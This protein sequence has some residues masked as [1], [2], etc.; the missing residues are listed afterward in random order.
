MHRLTVNE[1]Y[2][3]DIVKKNNELLINGTSANMDIKK[4]HGNAWHAINNLQSYNIEV[5]SFNKA[6]KAARIKVNNNIYIVS[7][8]DEFDILLDGLGLNDLTMKKGGDVKAPM[9]GMV[10]K[11]FIA[12]GMEVKKD[13]NLFI[14]EAMKME[15]IIKA[16]LD[17]IVKTVKVNPGGKVEKNQVLL[18][19]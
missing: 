10:L 4:L 11:V 12:E 9:P 2:N 17:F 5:V 6:D 7:G 15:N 13:E 3:F 16:P 8:K 14:L 19:F 18:T 1:K